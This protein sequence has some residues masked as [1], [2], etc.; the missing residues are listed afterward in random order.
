MPGHQR[1]AVRQPAVRERHA[2][3][4]RGAE[5]GG[6]SGND[7]PRDTV[8]GEHLEL[9]AATTEDQRIAALEARHPLALARQ[10][11]QQLVDTLLLSAIADFLAD[12]DPLGIAPCALEDRLGNQ[13]VVENHVRLLQQLQRAQRE[14]IRIAGT[15]A[16]EVDLP[17]SAPR[18][19]RAR[20]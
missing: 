12:E 10:A 5:R 20:C 4:G 19:R 8:G 18:R 7:A 6:D 13:P 16:D 9:L 11:H 15:G 1:H 17:G 14:Q 2:G 3:R